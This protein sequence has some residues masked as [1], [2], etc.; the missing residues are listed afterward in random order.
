M[1]KHV[2]PQPSG[3]REFV[4]G[5]YQVERQDNAAAVQLMLALIAAGIA[6]VVPV[7]SLIVSR[8]GSALG[9]S[10]SEV[11]HGLIALAPIPAVALFGFL[12]ANQVT[13]EA[14]SY[15]LEDLE[16]ELQSLAPEGGLV[17]PEGQTNVIGLAYRAPAAAFTALLSHL[18]TGAIVGTMLVVCA[19]LL[20]WPWPGAAMVLYVPAIGAIMYTAFAVA[21]PLNRRRT[22]LHTPR[23]AQVDTPPAQVKNRIRETDD[24]AASGESTLPNDSRPAGGRPHMGRQPRHG[25]RK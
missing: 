18:G 21:M 13:I 19:G 20:P 6:Y 1:S 15:Y 2:E 9:S 14:R 24:K 22:G 17:V 25:R 5:L 11:N 4:F 10:C 8:C 23:R 12:V 3:R 7:L 16:R